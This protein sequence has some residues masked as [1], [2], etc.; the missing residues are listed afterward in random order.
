LIHHGETNE[1]KE[2]VFLKVVREVNPLN[3]LQEDRNI[4]LPILEMRKPSMR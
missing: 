2:N 1:T 3:N 4:V